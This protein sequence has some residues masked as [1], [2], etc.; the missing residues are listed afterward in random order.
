MEAPSGIGGGISRFC[1]ISE[2][3]ENAVT[4]QDGSGREEVG[5]LEEY[6]TDRSAEGGTRKDFDFPRN[7]R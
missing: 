6:N 1:I 2:V 4:K 5:S 7:S 3:C